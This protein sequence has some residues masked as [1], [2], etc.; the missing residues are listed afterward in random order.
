MKILGISNSF[1]QNIAG[2]KDL[3]QHYDLKKVFNATDF[4]DES[5]LMDQME[6]GTY[7]SFPDVID[8]DQ[9]SLIMLPDNVFHY[10]KGKD[11]VIIHIKLIL[12]KIKYLEE[13]IESEKAKN[14]N[15]TSPA[16]IQ[17]KKKQPMNPESRKNK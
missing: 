1:P 11:Q 4:P 15:P 8:G 2:S 17:R 14:P 9:K 10:G 16:E 5:Y 7:N 12:D 3:S 13:K 6:K